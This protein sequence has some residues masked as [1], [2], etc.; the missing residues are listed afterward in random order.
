MARWLM[1]S[2]DPYEVG[3]AVLDRLMQHNEERKA[4]GAALRA[5]IRQIIDAEPKLSSREVH[6]KLTKPRALRTV[7]WH[8]QNIRATRRHCAND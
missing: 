8:L 6:A 2:P 3:Q 7:Q 4:Q 1:T 5:E